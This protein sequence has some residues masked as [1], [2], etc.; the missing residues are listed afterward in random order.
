MVPLDR[1][2]TVVR[3]VRTPVPWLFVVHKLFKFT[4][5]VRVP[6]AVLPRETLHPLTGLTLFPRV[7]SSVLM[8]L[9]AALLNT[10]E[11]LV[12][13]LTRLPAPV[14]ELL[15]STLKP[16]NR[17]LTRAVNLPHLPPDKLMVRVVRLSYV[18]T[19][20]VL[21][22]N[23]APML[24]MSRRRLVVVPM[25]VALTLFTP[26][27]MLVEVTVDVTLEMVASAPRRTATTLL[28]ARPT[29]P[30]V[31]CVLLATPIPT[32]EAPDVMGVYSCLSPLTLLRL[33]MSR[34]NVAF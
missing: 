23:M 21:L 30:N 26:R 13:K 34:S 12:F 6:N 28:A 27:T 32:A 19:R 22:L 25:Y 16:R 1:V 3:A 17:E 20:P 11:R 9:V 2:A 8:V 14:V 10:E 15:M 24:F 31:L 4:D 29:V 33:T 7:E 5:V 18:S